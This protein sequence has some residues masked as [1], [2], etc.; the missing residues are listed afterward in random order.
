M[1]LLADT[2]VWID[3]LGGRQ[4]SE[5][6]LLD[7]ALDTHKILM[8][9]LILLEILQGLKSDTE[10]QRILRYFKPFDLV[11]L[12]TADQIRPAANHYRRLR[13]LGVTVRKT[14]DVIIGSYCIRE[15]L[16][17]LFSDRDFEPLVK[18]CGLIRFKD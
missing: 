16:P 5:T 8:G 4:T 2:S 17:L 12:L 1:R 9:D 15:K 11:Q 7:A 18:H 10:E 3:Y 13:S 14:V 6:R